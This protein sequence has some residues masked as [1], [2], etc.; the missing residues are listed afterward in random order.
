MCVKE[1]TL[2]QFSLKESVTLAARL[3]T[4]YGYTCLSTSACTC[5]QFIPNDSHIFFSWGDY[6]SGSFNNY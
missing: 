5:M 4:G 1:S 2:R 6:G 3:Q